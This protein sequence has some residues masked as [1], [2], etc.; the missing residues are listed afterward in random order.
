MRSKCLFVFVCCCL[1]VSC[2]KRE[3][4]DSVDALPEIFPDYIGVTVPANICPLN[5]SVPDA[6][7][8]RAIITNDKGETLEVSGSDHIEMP[9][10]AWK[11]A[12]G[13]LPALPSVACAPQSL[14]SQQAIAPLG[15][16]L[17]LPAR[18][19][20]ADVQGVVIAKA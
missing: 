8:I 3:A 15:E 20:S 14:C 11:K 2:S 1:L 19:A 6:E 17:T 12:I 10:K 4:K 9:V 18:L 13:P 7:H 5:F 16:Y